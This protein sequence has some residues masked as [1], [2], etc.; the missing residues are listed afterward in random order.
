[1]K[2]TP[3]ANFIKLFWHNL[4]CHQHIALIFDSG[5]AA[6]GIDYAKKIMKLTPVANIIKLFGHNLHCYQHIGLIV[7]SGY[8]ARCI[9]YAKKFYEIDTSGQFHTSFLA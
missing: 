3:V 7:D 4:Y 2:L 6:S 9:N 1:M 8:A 5:N